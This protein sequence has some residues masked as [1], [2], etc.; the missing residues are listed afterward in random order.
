[1]LEQRGQT[2]LPKEGETYRKDVLEPEGGD[3]LW[4]ALED[5]QILRGPGE[6]AARMCRWALRKFSVKKEA[7]GQAERKG[8][9][10]EVVTGWEGGLTPPGQ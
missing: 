6:K 3:R 5:R 9:K 7:R 4:C 10:D 2:W 8:G 1:M